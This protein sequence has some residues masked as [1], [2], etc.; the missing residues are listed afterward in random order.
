MNEARVR[1]IAREEIA[2][3]LHPNCAVCGQPIVPGQC[4]DPS[5]AFNCPNVEEKP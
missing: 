1:A 4:G 3:A 5:L 2:R